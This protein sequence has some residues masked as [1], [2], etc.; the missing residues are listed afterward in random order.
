[1]RME[2]CRLFSLPLTGFLVTGSSLKPLDFQPLKC[3]PTNVSFRGK[4]KIGMRKPLIV[5][6]TYRYYKIISLLCGEIHQNIS[7]VELHISDCCPLCLFN[8]IYSGSI[9]TIGQIAWI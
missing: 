7:S 2:P 1:M 9:N 4:G 8:L 6:A 5:Q 3:G